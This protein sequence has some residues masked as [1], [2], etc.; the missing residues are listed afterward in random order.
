MEAHLI[1]F[2]EIEIEGRHYDFDVVIAGGIVGKRKKKGSKS[3]RDAYGHTPLSTTEELPWG[4]RQLIVG[5]GVS[6]SLPIM[7][8][9]MAEAERRGVDLVAV[10]TG[11]ACRL[12]NELD[13]KD[14]YAVLHITC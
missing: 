2:G 4:G 3:L 8:E 14:V 12:L 11:E 10:S 1:R 13:V 9:V 5:T 6:G 7:P